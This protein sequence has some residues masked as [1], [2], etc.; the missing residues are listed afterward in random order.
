VNSISAASAANAPVLMD[1]D[2]NAQ[3]VSS[4]DALLQQAAGDFQQVTQEQANFPSSSDLEAAFADAVNT[5]ADNAVGSPPNAPYLVT[6][7]DGTGGEGS[8][9]IRGTTDKSGAICRPTPPTRSV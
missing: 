6:L 1:A 5:I 7:G 2:Q 3:E 4:D 9:V 8:Q